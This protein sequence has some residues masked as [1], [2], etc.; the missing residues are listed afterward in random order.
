[1]KTIVQ[2]EAEKLGFNSVTFAGSID[3]ADYYAVGVIDKNGDFE[4]VGLPTFIA[5]KDGQ[6]SWI[7]GDEGLELCC[8]LEQP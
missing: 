5:L 2:R 4:P 6:T 7:C 8:K 3:G 1:M